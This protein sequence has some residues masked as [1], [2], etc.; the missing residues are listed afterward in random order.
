MELESGGGGSSGNTSSG[1]GRG[2]SSSRALVD[3]TYRDFSRYLQHAGQVDRHKKVE[4]NFPAKLH[5]ML[6]DPHF[7][8]VIVW[9]V[10]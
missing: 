7:A 4:A 6:S 9:M 2:R 3:H 5:Q 1:S 8:H 10:R